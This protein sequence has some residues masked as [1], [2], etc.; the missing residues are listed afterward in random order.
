MKSFRIDIHPELRDVE[1]IVK[2]GEQFSRHL[3]KGDNYPVE[4]QTN[5]FDLNRIKK[6][7]VRY[8]N[9]KSSNRGYWYANCREYAMNLSVYGAGKYLSINTFRPY[10]AEKP[11]L[12]DPITEIKRKEEFAS[13]YIDYATSESVA[14]YLSWNIFGVLRH[15]RKCGLLDNQSN[16][17]H[18]LK[19]MRCD[20]IIAKYLQYEGYKVERK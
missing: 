13:K 18:I 8:G 15:I 11:P 9:D 12:Y 1:V 3:I 7:A 6:F 4:F 5:E 2:N 14:K 17:F 16:V 10:G 19:W 20:R